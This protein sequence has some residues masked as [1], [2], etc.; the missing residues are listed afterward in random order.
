MVAVKDVDLVEIWAKN[1]TQTMT[2]YVIILFLALI[3]I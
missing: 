2:D 1:V 3:M